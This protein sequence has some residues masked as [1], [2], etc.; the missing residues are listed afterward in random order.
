MEVYSGGLPRD[1]EDVG[2]PLCQWGVT[3]SPLIG[4]LAD[5]LDDVLEAP[6]LSSV[7]NKIMPSPWLTPGGEIYS[8]QHLWGK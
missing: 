6:G 2:P 1:G 8:T 4:S 7:L 5:N 3:R